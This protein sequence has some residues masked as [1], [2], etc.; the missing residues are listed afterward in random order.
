MVQEQWCTGSRGRKPDSE[1]EAEKKL[2]KAEETDTFLTGNFNYPGEWG[3]SIK[4]AQNN[5]GR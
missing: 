1:L 3:V 4:K 5:Y 2:F